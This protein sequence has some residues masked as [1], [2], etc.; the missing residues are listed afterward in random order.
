M[1]P[2]RAMSKN[3]LFIALGTTAN[4][5]LSA[6]PAGAASTAEASAARI[7][8]FMAF[9]L[10]SAA[11]GSGRSENESSAKLIDQHGDDDDYADEDLLP[12]GVGADQHEAVANHFDQRRPDNRACRADHRGR[13]YPQLVPGREIGGSRTQP[14][15]DQHAAEAAGKAAQH[16]DGDHDMRNAHAGQGRR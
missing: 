2:S 3:G 4:L 5:S 14:A 16:I 13:D 15:G 11:A 8:R 7:T 9:L 6:A 10:R 1:Q 12:I